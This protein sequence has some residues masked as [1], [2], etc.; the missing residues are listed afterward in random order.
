MNMVTRRIRKKQQKQLA[1]DNDQQSKKDGAGPSYVVAEYFG[2]MRVY[3]NVVLEGNAS[4]QEVN[5]DVI[6][7]HDGM[8]F[9]ERY[10]LLHNLSRI[11]T[12][13]GETISFDNLRAEKLKGLPSVIDYKNAHSEIAASFPE[14][15]FFAGRSAVMKIAKSFFPQEQKKTLRSIVD[16][17]FDPEKLEREASLRE[18]RREKE[19]YDAWLK[20]NATRKEA[21]VIFDYARSDTDRWEDERTSGIINN[22]R[23]LLLI[24]DSSSNRYVMGLSNKNPL[25]TKRGED[26]FLVNDALIITPYANNDEAVLWQ[27]M[28]LLNNR[29]DNKYFFEAPQ[30]SLKLKRSNTSIIAEGERSVVDYLT[31]EEGCFGVAQAVAEHYGLARPEKPLSR[32][33]RNK[34]D[35]PLTTTIDDEWDWDLPEERAD[36]TYTRNDSQQ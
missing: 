15:K 1:P 21:P 29:H 23:E 26:Y 20:N 3:Q 32:R 2:M 8:D 36:Y 34:K 17:L 19:R 5:L 12:Y 10:N 18:Q 6:G 13:E 33:Q 22:Q 9:D 4:L 27:E 7:K 24:Y 28:M 30:R 25:S 35:E 16:N 31:N 11:R 14:L